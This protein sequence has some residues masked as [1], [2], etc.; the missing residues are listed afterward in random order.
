VQYARAMTTDTG[1]KSLRAA[2]RLVLGVTGSIACY[3][4]VGLARYFI[5][6]GYEVRVVMSDSATKFVTPLTFA[7]LTGQPVS[8]S[9]WD[10]SKPGSI[11]HI[12]LAD[13]ADVV[14]IAPATADCI[15]K[16]AVGSA[17][18]YLLGVVLATKAPLVV[19][20]A[21]NVNMY[22]HPQTQENID[23]LRARGVQIV[24]PETGELACKWTG[25]GRLASEYEIFSQTERAISTQD[26]IGVRVLVTAGP[27]R[28][29]LDPVRYL[30]NRSS[31]KMGISLAREAY[32]RGASVTLVHG[33]LSRARH[34]PSEVR[35]VPVVSAAEMGVAVLDG[36]FPD[37]GSCGYDIVIMAAAVADYRPREIATEKLKKS[38]A[39]LHLEL[40]QNLDIA[41]ALGERRGS[42]RAPLLVGF[43]VETGNYEQLRV[44]AMRKVSAK[45]LDYVVGNLAQD[46][47][48]RDTN[49]VM[50][51]SREG[52]LAEVA[53][54]H[55][56]K[57]ARAIWDSLVC[58]LGRSDK[59]SQ[60]RPLFS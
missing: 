53:E 36:V 13:W 1:I 28:E 3:K 37:T 41:R 59:P 19:A 25:K 17:E 35:C 29:A 20:P 47:L 21:M 30:S 57:V 6:R 26:L 11:G 42:D 34:V 52:V 39:S 55:K 43:A 49:R 2:K 8:S 15:S 46:S 40:T 7:A 18:S 58:S 38:G 24:E 56:R 10:E 14:L 23:L 12:E 16:L 9:F 32:R 50:I 27:T 33:P 45:G 5:K 44:E 4:A 54:A 22:E 48:D 51:V 31:G 60:M